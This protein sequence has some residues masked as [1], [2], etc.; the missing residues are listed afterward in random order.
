MKAKT[1]LLALLFIIAFS[2]CQQPRYSVVGNYK[3]TYGKCPVYPNT[4]HYRKVGNQFN[5]NNCNFIRK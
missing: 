3:I 5:P 4:K 1:L 2:R